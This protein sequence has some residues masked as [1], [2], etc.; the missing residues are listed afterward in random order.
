MVSVAH[1]MPSGQLQFV[2]VQLLHV[3]QLQMLWIFLLI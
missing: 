2:T 1:H 3:H